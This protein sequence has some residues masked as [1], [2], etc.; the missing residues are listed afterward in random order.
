MSPRRTITLLVAATA[1]AGV[2]AVPAGARVTAS[3]GEVVFAGKRTAGGDSYVYGV[4]SDGTEARRLPLGKRNAAWWSPN[5]ARVVVALGRLTVMNAD[6]SNPVALG[7]SCAGECDVAWNA[8]GTWIAYT[9]VERARA[10]R[11]RPGSPRSGRTAPTGRSCCG[12]SAPPSRAPHGRPTARTIAFVEEASGIQDLN[13]VGA[14]GKGFT[15]LAPA[16]GGH[17]APLYRPVWT[18]DGKRILF[19]ARRGGKQRV[20]SITRT[21]SDLQTLATGWW[22]VLSPDGTT[23]A[24]VAGKDDGYVAPLAGGTATLV[25]R[26]VASPLLWSPDG[27]ELA[28]LSERSVVRVARASGGAPPTSRPRLR[29]SARWRGARSADRARAPG[30]TMGS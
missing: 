30:S 27:N 7:V 2:L 12:S 20:L 21:G 5:G 9:V 3:P 23:I 25:A 14:R 15:R 24:F 8:N 1:F 28:Y 13:L 19:S 29:P 22:P 18:D 11:A 4:A 10:P 17:F 6:G 16:D 26:R